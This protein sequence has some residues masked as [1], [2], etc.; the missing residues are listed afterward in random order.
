MV[1][2]I[3]GPKL[4]VNI[5]DLAAEARERLQRMRNAKQSPQTENGSDAKLSDACRQMESLFIHH[6]FKEKV[7]SQKAKKIILTTFIHIKKPLIVRYCLRKIILK[8]LS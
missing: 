3:S 2:F 8:R 6:L 1:D 5:A 4:P 7:A